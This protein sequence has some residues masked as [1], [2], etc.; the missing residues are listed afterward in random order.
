MNGTKIGDTTL[1][2][3]FNLSRNNA[4]AA[5]ALEGATLYVEGLINQNLRT[6]TNTNAEITQ[7]Y[8]T[9]VRLGPPG[10]TVVPVTS[11]STLS[12][13]RSVAATSTSPAAAP[14]ATTVRPSSSALR[15]LRKP[16]SSTASGISP[17][18][19]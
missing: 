3:G 8:L 18:V 13:P 4:A 14:M 7:S 19:R 15:N 5:Y 10:R 16:R 17:S 1:A 9:D 12:A 6:D 2:Y 11:R